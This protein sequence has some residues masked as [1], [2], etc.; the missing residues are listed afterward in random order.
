MFNPVPVLTNDT[1]ELICACSMRAFGNMSLYY[2]DTQGALENRKI[3]LRGK[4]ID[5]RDLVC[6]KQV[7]GSRVACIEEPDKGR[8]A[9]YY[10]NSIPDTDALITDKKKLPL[11]IFTADC[12]SIFLYDYNRPA[13]GL[14]HA[15][16]RSTKDNIA[17]KAIGLM[18][19]KFNTQAKDLYVGF[20]PSIRGCCY[21]VSREFSKFFPYGLAQRKSRAY[22]DLAKINKKHILGLGVKEQNILDS[23]L[24]TSCQNKEF[25]SY[26]KDGS[27]SGRMMSVMMLR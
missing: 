24:C 14:V 11:A 21:E 5:Y 25:F 19:E 8:G 22:L 4:G 27:S 15:G 12:L 9:V 18:R 1:E 2:G 13:I 23:G 17:S 3:F 16:W 26:R 7:H 6:A 20:S 10:H